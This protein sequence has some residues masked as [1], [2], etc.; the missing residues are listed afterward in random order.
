M[1][2]MWGWSKQR[3]VALILML[4]GGIFAGV[5]MQAY[6]LFQRMELVHELT[7]QLNQIRS[8][9]SGESIERLPEA[10]AV[11]LQIQLAQ[12]LRWRLVASDAND[13]HPNVESV[14]GSSAQFLS[15]AEHR[16]FA[17]LSLIETATRLASLRQASEHNE[18]LAHFYYQ[19]TS[20][21]LDGL[22]LPDLQQGSREASLE[23]KLE[24]GELKPL[25]RG[26]AFRQWQQVRSVLAQYHQAMDQQSHLFNHQVWHD[27]AQYTQHY[28]FTLLAL[29]LTSIMASALGVTLCAVVYRQRD[30]ARRKHNQEMSDTTPDTQQKQVTSNEFRQVKTPSDFDIPADPPTKSTGAEA[31]SDLAFLAQLPTASAKHSSISQDAPPRTLLNDAERYTGASSQTEMHEASQELIQLPQLLASMGENSGA[32]CDVLRL[33]VEEHQ[34]DCAVIKKLALEDL[35]TAQRQ[36]HSIKGVA[37]SLAAAPLQELTQRLERQIKSGNKPTEQQFHDLSYLLEQTL[38]Q[39]RVIVRHLQPEAAIET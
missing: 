18:I 24:S 2:Q 21:L 25:E 15:Q 22:L 37:G 32:V 23:S 4:C 11:A 12:S 30:K 1:K 5:A 38:M 10:D 35:V 39:A 3:T 33:F 31:S 6:H 16:V 8:H 9:F 14:A 7:Y 29:S 20:Q 27:V 17:E 19:L 34:H 36:I 28:Y 26:Q 13:W